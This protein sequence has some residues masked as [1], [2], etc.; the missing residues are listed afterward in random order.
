M[1][2]SFPCPKCARVLQPCGVIA[3]DEGPEQPVY[4]CDECLTPSEVLGVKMDMA[5]T[6]CID[7]KGRV[8]NPAD[9]SPLSFEQ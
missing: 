7:E 9:H 6:F 8:F 2:D 4:Q 5:L 3:V 1:S